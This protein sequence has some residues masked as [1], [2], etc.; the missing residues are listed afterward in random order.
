MKSLQPIY[1]EL[2]FAPAA[3]ATTT[4]AKSIDTL[5]A[6]NLC[7]SLSFSANL[8]TNAAGPTLQ[9][10]HSDT[11]AAT[12][13]VTF[14][15]ALNR[16]VSRGTAGVISVSH[17]KLDGKVK[18]YVQL[19]VTPGTTTN[20]TVSYGGVALEDKEIRPSAVADVGGSAVLS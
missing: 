13:F 8:N 18:R 15:A 16:S 5:G 17:I 10:A 9:F 6:K 14:D 3:A 12:A 11:D 19:K 1:Q 4:A 2:V 20:D 7:V